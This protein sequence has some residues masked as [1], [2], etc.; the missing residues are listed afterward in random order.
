MLSRLTNGQA[1]GIIG[2]ISYKIWK[3]EPNGDMKSYLKNKLEPKALKTLANLDHSLLIPLEN[4]LRNS[5]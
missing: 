5:T 3:L 4:Q 2:K 1:L